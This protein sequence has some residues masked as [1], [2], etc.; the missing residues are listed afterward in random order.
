MRKLK[1]VTKQKKCE[2]KTAAPANY[3]NADTTLLHSH[4]EWFY[5]TLHS[6]DVIMHDK[7]MNSKVA[8]TC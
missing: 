8:K 4:D 1:T 7:C 3:Q 5:F 2:H 6:T